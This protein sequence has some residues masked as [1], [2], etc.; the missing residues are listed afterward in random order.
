MDD[1]YTI[2]IFIAFIVY[3]IYKNYKKSTTKTP[4]PQSENSE[5]ETVKELFETFFGDEK[6]FGSTKQVLTE[7]EIKVQNAKHLKK[8]A[9][10]RKDIEIQ[11]RYNA[12]IENQKSSLDTSRNK[13]KNTSTKAGNSYLS[14]IL[15]SN[16][17][18]LRKA[19]LYN[20]ILESPYKQEY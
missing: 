18:E 11:N 7:K 2:L 1:F 15:H 5:K 17:N 16:K 9:S 19:I 4:A 6:E 13:H 12:F 8:Q 20:A 10:L 14:S 3:S